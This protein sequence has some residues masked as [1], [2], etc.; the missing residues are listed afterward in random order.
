M[1]LFAW[2]MHWSAGT[3]KGMLENDVR[4]SRSNRKFTLRRDSAS[5]SF[6]RRAITRVDPRFAPASELHRGHR[7][8]SRDDFA[9]GAGAGARAH[10]AS[11]A[12]GGG[13]E[14][15]SRT[16]RLQCPQTLRASDHRG[17]A[18][19]LAVLAIEQPFL[20]LRDFLAKLRQARQAGQLFQVILQRARGSSPH[21]LALADDLGREDSTA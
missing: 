20:Q 17:S 11:A 14:R 7:I 18:L 13:S 12:P 21:Y 8:L 4:R 6:A 16:Q 10:D 19:N 1:V 3:R 2:S 9:G 15:R 5:G